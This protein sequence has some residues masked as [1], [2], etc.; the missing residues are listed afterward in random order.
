[1][2]K[3]ESKYFNTSKKMNDALI[4]LL[5]YKDYEYITIKDVCQKANVNRST[6]YLHYSNMNDLLKEIIDNLNN[7]FAS[8]FKSNEKLILLKKDLND[9]YFIKDEFLIPYLK[10]IEENKKI[11]K[12]IRNHPSLFNVN[13]T[14]NNYFN[15]IFSPIMKRFGLEEKWHKYLMGFYVNGI[16]S[17]ILDWVFDDCKIPINEVCNFI[18]GIVIKHD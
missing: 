10:F 3:S 9:L 16:S 2:N 17:I 5:D 1:M 7:S 4:S 18:K 14:Y 12:A 15:F 11:Y 13:S 8:H 6:F